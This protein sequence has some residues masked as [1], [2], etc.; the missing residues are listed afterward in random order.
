MDGGVAAADFT[1]GKAQGM[2]VDVTGDT[3]TFY[4]GATKTEGV[5]KTLVA[6]PAANYDS[7]ALC[8]ME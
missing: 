2:K 1:I 6:T 5:Y 8:L 7:L 3:I 4:T